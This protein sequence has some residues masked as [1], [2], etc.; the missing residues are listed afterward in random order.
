MRVRRAALRALLV[1]ALAA[2]FTLVGPAGPADAALTGFVRVS[3]FTATTSAAK[4]LTATC[5]AGTRVIGA[6][7]DTTP[8][9]GEVLL[10]VLRPNSALTSVTLHANEDA[11][12]TTAN[13]YLQAFIICATAPVGLE[14]VTATSASTSAGTRSVAATCPGGKRL[15]GSGAEILGAPSQVLLDGQLPNP[16]LTAVTVNALEDETGTSATWSIKAHAICAD[17]IPGLQRV[18]VTGA[19]DSVANKV[20]TAPCPAGKSVIGLG[21]TINSPNG[22]VVLDAVFP[23]L[24]MTNANISAFE[25]G[26]GNDATWSLTAYAICADSAQLKTRVVNRD[27]HLSSGVWTGAGCPAGQAA[28][29]V[30]GDLSGSLG[31]LGLH[32]LAPTSSSAQVGALTHPFET[33]ENWGLTVQ[34]ICT[35]PFPGQEVVSV[36]SPSDSQEAK[37]A[38]VTC[39]AGKR[40]LGAGAAIGD[41]NL[42]TSPVVLETMR[43]DAA[44]TT[45]T[46]RGREEEG[47]TDSNWSVRAYAVCAVAPS[48]LQRVSATTVA[49]SDEFART[50]VSCPA[51]KHLVGTG[52]E[53]VG[54]L[55]EVPLDE[56]SADAALTRT[57]VTGFE[58]Q[59]GFDRNWRVTA[60]AVCITR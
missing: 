24:D 6:G 30:G 52:G 37:T 10:D 26:T 56:I 11:D 15:L 18:L 3:P 17:P 36:A 20:V 23:D 33:Q 14:L 54:G 34:A 51:G 27:G 41:G 28:S 2:G 35:T 25:D 38:T 45:V 49:G 31:R 59:T 22:Q 32:D 39:P 19:T 4:S 58:D 7:G 50:S 46:A 5:P 44:L 12:G 42:D 47:G 57:Q 8:G 1:F 9:S 21:G 55:G 29:G 48:G 16:G 13:W 43:P 53:V 40:V 60:Y